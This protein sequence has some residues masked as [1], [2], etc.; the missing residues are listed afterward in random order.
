M[1]SPI[2]LRGAAMPIARCIPLLLL[3]A[4]A[5]CAAE[6]LEPFEVFEVGQPL[7]SMQAANEPGLSEACR[8]WALSTADAERFLNLSERVDGQTLH[9]YYN[10]LPCRIEGRL[11]DRSGQ[12]WNFEINAASVASLWQQRD[13]R[14]F[15]GCRQSGCEPLV[16]MMP[17]SGE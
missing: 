16:L 5:A 8:N 14:Q 1:L 9:Q 12:L 6:P 11:R 3:A 2:A 17:E 7:L 15:R 4:G 10:W 13:D